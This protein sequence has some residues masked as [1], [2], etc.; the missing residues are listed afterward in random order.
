MIN[1]SYKVSHFEISKEI[2]LVGEYLQ[3]WVEH[4]SHI[5]MNEDRTVCFQELK[6]FEAPLYTLFN[7]FSIV[8]FQLGILFWLGV[9]N[10]NLNENTS[11]TNTLSRLD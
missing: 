2:W 6:Y 8:E 5:D 1:F 7:R 3:I 4:D 9:N 11:S 10:T